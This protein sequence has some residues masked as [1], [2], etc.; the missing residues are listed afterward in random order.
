MELRCRP[1]DLA[2]VV[3]AELP[4]NLGLIVRVLRRHSGRGKLALKNKGPLWTVECAQ[5]MTY[6]VKGQFFSRSR[7]PVPDSYLQ[8]IRGE[9]PPMS[10][11]RARAVE[12]A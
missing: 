4:A 10:T 1:G 8:P 6:K 2:V 7:A 12:E 3:F 11:S 9:S 5:P